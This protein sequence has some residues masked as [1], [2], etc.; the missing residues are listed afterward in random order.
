MKRISIK[1]L[2]V[3]G[4]SLAL[5]FVLS[6]IKLWSWPNGGSITACS[7]VFVTIIGWFFGPFVGL[8]SAFAYAVLQFVQ[9]PV[10]LSIPQVLFDYF[11][12]FTALGISGFFYK[13]KEGL[14]I[15]YV[16]AVLLRLI[17]ATLASLLF[18]A[19]YLE[20]VFNINSLFL[21]SLFYNGSYILPEAVITA[22]ILLLP[23]VK[24]LLIKLKA[25]LLSD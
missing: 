19:E 4:V 8:I 14:I 10:I 11:F 25:R 7:M 2:A 6:C 21:A 24:K 3:S 13:K 18:W 20:P 15:G 9:H 22:V 5:A 17:F 16:I 1:T 12:A 23:P